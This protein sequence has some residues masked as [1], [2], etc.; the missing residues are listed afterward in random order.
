MLTELVWLP[1]RS[2][3]DVFAA[4]QKAREAAA[5][6]GMDGND[7]VRVATAVSELGRVIVAAHAYARVVI[8]LA[9]LRGVD[10]LQIAVYAD[11]SFVLV[12]DEASGTGMGAGR[13]LMDSV[14]IVRQYPAIVE[15]VKAL[16][17]DA[18]LLRGGELAAVRARLAGS[19]VSSPLDELRAQ[20]LE[21]LAAL[22]ELRGKQEELVQLNVEL[23][24][25][26]KGV[27]AMYAQLSEELEETNRGVVA[28]Y[29]ELDERGAQL[30]HASEAK[31]RFLA[32]VS[33]ELRGPLNS[34]LGLVRLL[35]EPDSEP[36]TESQSHLVRLLHSAAEEL[37]GLVN[38]LL[39]LAKAE[40]GRLDPDPRP[41]DLESVLADLRATMRPLGRKG[42]ELLLDVADDARFIETDGPLLTQVLRNLVANALRFT[43]LG[44]VLVSAVAIPSANLL[45]IT[46]DDTGVGIAPEHQELVFEEFFQV[47]G[48]LQSGS[49]NTGLGLPYA[50]RVAEALGG[51]LSL[52]S[53]VGRGSTFTLLLPARWSLPPQKALGPEP[54]EG[55][56][57]R[58]GT[59]LVVDDE[60][61]FRELLRAMLQG[62]AARV[63]EAEDGPGALELMRRVRPDVVLLDLRMPGGG[64]E[65]VLAHTR[66][67]EDL[68][69]IP[70]V[71][72]TSVALDDV[73]LRR[74]SP[75]VSV[76]SKSGLTT[77]SLLASMRSA[78]GS[79]AS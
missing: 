27:M 34:L 62:H 40:S 53:Q 63:I 55:R 39:D 68:R 12:E 52:T 35:G 59:V 13:R 79:L 3:P 1:L 7:Q 15:L 9:S 37:L 38:D 6:L 20:N 70:I 56:I 18:T 26:N 21:L 19:V 72:V 51:S 46:V 78:L 58:F 17:R 28:L 33:H 66:T 45:T 8:S 14:R 75:A 4:R 42:V 44:R 24:E 32:N 11:E 16:P 22:E 50:R 31:S 25:T 64:G 48:P 5:A 60:A 10:Q 57:E 54:L 36:L 67:D 49:N 2:E 73:V 76:L 77:E 29:A 30:H 71:V 61:P 74:L 41:V 69:E 47:R 23:E 65:D 43:E